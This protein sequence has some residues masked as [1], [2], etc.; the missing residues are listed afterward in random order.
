MMIF[1]GVEAKLT[2]LRNSLGDD[3]IGTSSSI[4]VYKQEEGKEK[5]TR[6]ILD[7]NMRALKPND[8]ISVSFQ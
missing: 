5:P 4:K 2:E 3:S 6:L 1:L 7:S 8:R